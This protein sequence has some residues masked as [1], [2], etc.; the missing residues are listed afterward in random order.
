MDALA[1]LLEGPRARGAFV[2][3]SMLSPPW[4]LRIQDES[5]LTLVAVVRG[6]A[7]V[8]TADGEQ[9]RIEAG[10]VAV[11]RGTRPYTVADDPATEPQ[12]LINPGQVTTTLDGEVLC[13]T[14]SLGVRQWGNDPDGETVFVTG[15]Y[16]YVGA[17]SRRLLRALPPILVLPRGRS[18]DRLL[19]LLTDETVKDLPAQGVV[20][21]RLLDLLLISTLRT[22]FSG[23]EAPP[24]YHAYG[25]P[26]VGKALRLLQH[27]PAHPWTVAALAQEVGASRAALARRFTELVGEPPMAFLTEWRLDL[28]A[29]L[30]QGTEDTVEAIARRV[31]YGSAFALSTA[32]KRHFG[33]SPREHRAGGAA[34]V[35]S[36][37]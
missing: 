29:D 33:V 12:I 28:A 2:L 20:L 10:D 3:R 5:P 35:S 23:A 21:D 32:F 19:D 37:S 31:G 17:V 30:L 27:N 13:E 9:R 24:W 8:L 22:W 14:M 7:W 1:A 34:A 18:D 36:A 11:F 26:L 6:W 25:D 4:S 16:E 15:S